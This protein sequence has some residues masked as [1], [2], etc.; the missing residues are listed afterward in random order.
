MMRENKYILELLAIWPKGPSTRVLGYQGQ[1]EGGVL[2]K[3]V[4]QPSLADIRK[5]GGPVTQPGK[6]LA[7]GRKM[8]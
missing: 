2:G 5:N 6:G 3:Q 4:G 7:Q 1:R 8:N